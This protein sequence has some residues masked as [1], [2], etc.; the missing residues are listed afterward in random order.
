MKKVRINTQGRAR[1][2]ESSDEF[3]ACIEDLVNHPVVQEMKKYPHH[4]KTSCYQ[5]C[6]NVAYYNYEI[7][8]F[9]KLDA[10]SAARAGM[11]HDLFL[12]DWHEH[13][14]LT[15]DHF[16]GLTHPA[17]A[18]KNAKKYFQL[19]DI[20]EEMIKKH[21]W[22][23]TVIPPKVKEAYVICL[24]DK[25]CGSCETSVGHTPEF[26]KRKYPVFQRIVERVFGKNHQYRDYHLQSE[27]EAGIDNFL[28]SHR[29]SAGTWKYSSS[30]KKK[31][32]RS[33]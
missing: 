22:P 33:A 20:E 26:L 21:M 32:S 31:R 8:K 18:L 2:D 19:N 23:L 25:Y 13:T 17:V 16:H 27:Q 4:G 30:G 6:L 1:N 5:H 10:R 9:F 7:C 29:K 12:Y 11:L 15:G 3:Y 24:A 28:S 14:A